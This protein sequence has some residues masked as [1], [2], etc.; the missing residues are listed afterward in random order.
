MDLLYLGSTGPNVELLQYALNKANFNVGKIDGIFGQQTDNALRN[1]QRA[2]GLTVDGV[3][4]PR[5]WEALFPFINGYFLYTVRP[6]DSLY[7]ISNRFSSS[8][9]N[10][11]FANPDKNLSVIYPGQVIVV[12]TRKYCANYY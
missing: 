2:Y 8:V 12:P 11:I 7:S 1:F 6:G 9:N 4:G 5:T 3:A 10:I